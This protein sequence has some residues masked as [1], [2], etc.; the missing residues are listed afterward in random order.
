MINKNKCNN[1]E[2][3]DFINFKSFCVN[4]NGLNGNHFSDCPLPYNI[5]IYEEK[6]AKKYSLKI[7]NII[8]KLFK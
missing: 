3:N 7:K 8:N 1:T 5:P 6:K 2:T 4:C